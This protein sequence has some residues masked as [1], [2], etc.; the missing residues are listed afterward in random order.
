MPGAPWVQ[1][2]EG[3]VP[4]QGRGVRLRSGP[5]GRAHLQLVRRHQGI[6]SRQRGRGDR[7]AR[8]HRDVQRGRSHHGDLCRLLCQR[9][10]EGQGVQHFPGQ[11]EEGLSG[12][13]GFW[14]PA[15]ASEGFSTLSSPVPLTTATTPPN[16]QSV[17]VFTTVLTEGPGGPTRPAAP[18]KPVAPWQR[19]TERSEGE[20]RHPCPR[21]AWPPLPPAHRSAGAPAE[22]QSEVLTG[23]PALPRAPLGPG[24]PTLPWRTAQ[25]H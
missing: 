21:L 24:A 9:G 22:K 14:S 2:D 18:G 4:C 17:G 20:H 8:L 19:R 25:S 15:E 10:R 16:P 11:G 6:L 3:E 1:G 7:G 23:G 13:R 12:S 5:L